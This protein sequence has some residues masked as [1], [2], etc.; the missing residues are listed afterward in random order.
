[1][2]IIYLDSVDS[3][4]KYLKELI[5]EG[6]ISL[7]CAVVADSQTDGI[8]SRGNSWNGV[9]NNL[10]LSFATPLNEL[11]KDLKL[12]SA[13]IYFSYIL[14]E[15]LS[16]FDSAIWLKWPNDFYIGDKKIGGMI[17]NLVKDTLVCGV[18]LNIAEAPLGFGKLDVAV[19]RDKLIERYF[20]N[21]KKINLWKQVFSKYKIEFYK[22]QN[23]YTHNKNLIISLGDASL[24]S[25]GSIVING[26]R[27]YSLR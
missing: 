21:I 25:D 14:K 5:Q 15:T 20:N 12:E 13:S 17:T 26:E 24:C 3:T 6:K 27:M 10:F 4:Q 1:M 11:P 7:P 23:F 19:D 22:N 9:R 2:Q 18:G 8:G 16:E